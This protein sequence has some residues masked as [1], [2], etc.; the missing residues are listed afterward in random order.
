MLKAK[1]R[2]KINQYKKKIFKM[3]VTLLIKSI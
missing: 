1:Y 3:K 2:T